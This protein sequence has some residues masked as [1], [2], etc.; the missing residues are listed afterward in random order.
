[1]IDV[2]VGPR[3]DQLHHQAV[4]SKTNIVQLLRALA[5]KSDLYVAQAERF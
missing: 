2:R 5:Y 3:D 1:V 4:L